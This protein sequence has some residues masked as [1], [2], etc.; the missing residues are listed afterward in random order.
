MV[1]YDLSGEPLRQAFPAYVEITAFHG[2][3]VFTI[4]GT[5]DEIE[6]TTKTLDELYPDDD[7]RCLHDE[8][9]F[10]GYLPIE[11]NGRKHAVPIYQLIVLRKVAQ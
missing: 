9:R 2:V 6:A 8:A 1:T 7:R 10:A 3:Q 5:K 11:E 4:Q